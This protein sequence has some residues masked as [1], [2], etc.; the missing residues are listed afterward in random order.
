MKSLVRILP[1]IAAMAASMDGMGKGSVT[2]SYSGGKKEAMP[3][4]P[5]KV[6]PKGCKWFEFQHPINGWVK[7]AALS[8]DRAKEKFEKTL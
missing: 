6:L 5:P 3:K 1:L 7:I 4:N 8:Y 2:H